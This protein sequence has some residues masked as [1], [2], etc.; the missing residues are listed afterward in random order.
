MSG[1]AERKATEHIPKTGPLGFPSIYYSAGPNAIK[2]LGTKPL[3]LKHLPLQ[4]E[5]D[6]SD[7]SGTPA[8]VEK[9]NQLGLHQR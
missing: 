4:L 6:F 1:Y 2:I 9:T 8:N 5:T 7:P 3:S